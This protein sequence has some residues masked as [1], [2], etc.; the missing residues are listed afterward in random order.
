MFV[1]FYFFRRSLGDH[2]H[3]VRVTSDGKSAYR[4]TAES[5][6]ALEEVGR[7]YLGSRALPRSIRPAL[8]VPFTERNVTGFLSLATASMTAIDTALDH[9]AATPRAAS[10]ST[11]SAVGPAGARDGLS[12]VTQCSSA[13][14]TPQAEESEESRP[15]PGE[16]GSSTFQNLSIGLAS[17]VSP[18]CPF[19][20]AW[21][22][23]SGLDVD[24]REQG[25][26]GGRGRGEEG[27][28]GRN[29]GSV[30]CAS[31]RKQR[32]DLNPT[33]G[34]TET[35]TPVRQ[36]VSP[37][38]R[39]DVL[40]TLLAASAPSVH[41]QNERLSSEVAAGKAHTAVGALE[42]PEVGARHGSAGESVRLS[43]TTSEMGSRGSE[44]GAGGAKKQG[45]ED[46]AADAREHLV[47]NNSV[48]T[49]IV[50]TFV[51]TGSEGVC[52]D[53]F[54]A[55]GAAAGQ[56]DVSEASHVGDAADASGD[57]PSQ[58]SSTDRPVTTNTIEKGEIHGNLSRGDE[59][60]NGCVEDNDS[61]SSLRTRHD[62]ANSPSPLTPA[63]TSFR[64]PSREK[65]LRCTK[66]GKIAVAG[67][68][69][70]DSP[71]GSAP[72]AGVAR[73]TPRGLANDDRQS[74]PPPTA[75]GRT[76]HDNKI[77]RLDDNHPSEESPAA[78]VVVAVFPCTVG[79]S[80]EGE[81]LALALNTA[82]R[83]GGY[84]QARDEAKPTGEGGDSSAKVERSGAGER[85]MAGRTRR[86]ELEELEVKY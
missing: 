43:A 35:A 33:C 54:M 46:A 40:Q 15:E 8:Q 53:D 37:T 20:S 25:S 55:S 64:V 28:D 69:A 38:A 57:L 21:L 47:L 24:D 67:G 9:H 50:T 80:D 62:I 77:D 42:K 36:A 23:R 83:C 22:P 56:V 71:S 51:T 39:A 26:G 1:C 61:D 49:A 18:G 7:T 63:R 58:G 17:V 66:T 10:A 27:R 81:E 13:P 65:S 16:Q 44:K 52:T 34:A 14:R 70:N 4:G 82:T 86:K 48:D 73:R 84:G 12:D 68:Q 85:L 11:T 79:G 32:P 74:P 45:E 30:H 78:K 6:P 31:S 2:N 3:Q 60:R 5:L 59:H 75:M 72:P 41:G 29:H 76:Q 19:N